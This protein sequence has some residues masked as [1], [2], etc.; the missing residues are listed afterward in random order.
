MTDASHLLAPIVIVDA[1]ALPPA[2]DHGTRMCEP[3]GTR[4]HAIT[5]RFA[6]V[7]IL[8]WRQASRSRVIPGWS[9]AITGR[10]PSE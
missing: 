9:N 4:G 5:Y 1:P 2:L 8:L 6:V 10:N 3:D 7:W